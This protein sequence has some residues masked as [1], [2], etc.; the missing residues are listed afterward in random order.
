M[1]QKNL[2][3]GFICIVSQYLP[4]NRNEY[5][6]IINL[7]KK[8]VK[9]KHL[10]QGKIMSVNLMRLICC[11]KVSPDLD[12]NQTYLQLLSFFRGKDFS[13]FAPWI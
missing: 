2:V 13:G 12:F 11:Q 7:T 8:F 6:S 3:R 9:S 1:L 10:F 5:V 4:E